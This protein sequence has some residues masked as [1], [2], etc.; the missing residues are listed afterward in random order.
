MGEGRGGHRPPP[1]F[2]MAALG[3]ALSCS[4]PT[5]P[6][7]AG[8]RP[9]S[10]QVDLGK[11]DHRLRLAS[12]R[13]CQLQA[14]PRPGA[15]TSCPQTPSSPWCGAAARSSRPRASLGLSLQPLCASVSS[16]KPD[17]HRNTCSEG[18]EGDSE[19]PTETWPPEPR[20]AGSAPQARRLLPA[21]P[22]SG[23][24][25]LFPGKWSSPAPG[26]VG[27]EDAQA[28]GLFTRNLSSTLEFSELIKKEKYLKKK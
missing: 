25:P 27:L 19:V 15:S 10:S 24:R 6:P 13:P 3:S 11:G 2:P 12:R 26:P 16:L 1:R 18:S 5:P 4:S 23:L 22:S 8:P 28:R 7:A 14:R 20:G 17:A 9:E 21:A